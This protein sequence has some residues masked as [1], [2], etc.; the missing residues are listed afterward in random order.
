MSAHFSPAKHAVR[1][2]LKQKKKERERESERER[3]RER[4]RKREKERK[5]E[6]ARGMEMC[7]VFQSLR[8]S[9]A[10]QVESISVSKSAHARGERGGGEKRE[11]HE[12]GNRNKTQP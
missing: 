6:R 2:R 4:E 9:Q 5:R 7:A 1:C 3:E 11:K 8:R 10:C 12:A